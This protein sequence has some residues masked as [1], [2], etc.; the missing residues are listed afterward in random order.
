MP[1]PETDI[2]AASRDAELPDL[3]G[4][5]EDDAEASYDPD[6]I[7][8]SRARELGLGVGARDLRLQRDV[9]GGGAASYDGGVERLNSES[10]SADDL[11]D[12]SDASN[13]GI[14]EEFDTEDEGEDAERQDDRA[15]FSQVP[16]SDYRR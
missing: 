14:D 9:H 8:V 7:E 12:A 16:Q 13:L 5:D 11:L 3:E 4:P 2:S 6:G 10:L 1:D 15:T